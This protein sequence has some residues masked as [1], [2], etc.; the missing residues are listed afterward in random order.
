MLAGHCTLDVTKRYMAPSMDDQQA[1]VDRMAWERVGVQRQGS[2]FGSRADGRHSAR[3]PDRVWWAGPL[4]FP[5]RPTASMWHLLSRRAWW[6]KQ[7][8]AG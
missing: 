7:A 5:A 1:L 3:G 6:A 4:Q 2:F 8:G